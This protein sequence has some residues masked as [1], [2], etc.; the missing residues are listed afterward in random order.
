MIRV[1]SDYLK[2]GDL[3]LLKRFCNFVMLKMVK[4]AV[5]RKA[6]ISIR[7][8]KNEDL[9]H[10]DD[11]MDLKD[12][13]A[14]VIYEGIVDGK[15]KFNVV[16]NARRLNGKAKKPLYRIKK[17]MYDVAHELVHIKQYLNNELFDYVDGKARYKGQ[18][19]HSGHSDDLEKYFDSPWEIEAYGREYG[20]YKVF[21]KKIKKELKEK[22]KRES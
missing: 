15:R 8:I 20:L 4:P 9:D 1:T 18:V 12:Y 2:K 22:A 14:W 17:L 16:L 3:A 13:G 19:F 10:T 5:L 7:I 6:N 21:V 11:V